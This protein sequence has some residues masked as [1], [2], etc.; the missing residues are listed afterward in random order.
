MDTSAL[1]NDD[2]HWKYQMLLGMLNWV[3]TIGRFDVAH[4]TLSLS[5]FSSC[6][7]KGPHGTCIKSLWLPEEEEQLENC[8]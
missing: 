1:L 6:P 4:A 5:R 3:V 8:Y 2:E 7:R